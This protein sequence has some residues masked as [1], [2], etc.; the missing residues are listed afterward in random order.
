MTRLILW[1]ILILVLLRV[2]WMLL[3]G[4][5][6]GLGYQRQA[7]TRAVG[8]VRDPVCGTFVVPSRAITS[9]S[10]TDTRYFCSEKCRKDYSAKH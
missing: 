5:L 7:D 9:G 10:G 2:G 4:V 8:L 3:K 1:V 6:V